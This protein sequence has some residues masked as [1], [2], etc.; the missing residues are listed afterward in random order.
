RGGVQDG[1]TQRGKA[2]GEVEGLGWVEAS[3]APLVEAMKALQV[4]G[5]EDGDGEGRGGGLV[6]HTS[7]QIMP[8]LAIVLIIACLTLV[9]DGIH[10]GEAH[11]DPCHR[12]H[13]CPSDG[14][15]YVC[16]D[17]GRRDQCPDNQYCLAGQLRPAASSPSTSIPPTLMP[18]QPASPSDMTVCFT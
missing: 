10:H 9:A 7:T 5:G 12:L 2:R 16:G 3:G 14:H 8:R 1:C 13:S 17:K 6:S 15:T 4:R 18:G 11:Q